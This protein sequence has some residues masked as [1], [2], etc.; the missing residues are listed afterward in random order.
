MH[1]SIDVNRKLAL[2]IAAIVLPGGL[3]AL[4]G[5][6]VLKALAQTARGRKVVELARRRVP[7]VH[8][9]RVSLFRQQQAAA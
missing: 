1:T 5:A 6:M 4:L 3:L 8:A 9:L 7:R 2:I